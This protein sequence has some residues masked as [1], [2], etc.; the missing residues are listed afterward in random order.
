MINSQSIF[1]SR[2]DAR[3]HKCE[4]DSAFSDETQKEIIK[5]FCARVISYFDSLTI[6]NTHKYFLPSVASGRRLAVRKG[7]RDGW[8]KK[9]EIKW[10]AGVYAT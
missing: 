10:N 9:L 4:G 1:I 2:F 7:K 5:Y 8:E 6:N 3:G